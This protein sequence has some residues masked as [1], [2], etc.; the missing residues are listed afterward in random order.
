[1][2]TTQHHPSEQLTELEAVTAELISS[3][4]GYIAECDARWSAE[5][6]EHPVHSQFYSNHGYWWLLRR[7]LGWGSTILTLGVLVWVGSMIVGLVAR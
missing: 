2:A 1:M 7:V 3:T 4:F 6:Q 5:S